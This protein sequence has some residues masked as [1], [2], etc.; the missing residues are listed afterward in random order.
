MKRLIYFLIII[1]ACVLL[2]MGLSSCSKDPSAKPKVYAYKVGDKFT[3]NLKD[4]KK[5][6]VCSV[7]FQVTKKSVADKSTDTN[8]I[9]R[10]AVSTIL[11]HLTEEDALDST[12][13][14]AIEQDM[15]DAANEAMDTDVFYSA[16]I[17]DWT[18][19]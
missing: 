2:T 5:M 7:V 13:L 12:D 14:K 8:Y 3:T 16:K 4:S 6:L 19:S 1:S 15:T 9:V 11:L 18:V 17:T 10:N